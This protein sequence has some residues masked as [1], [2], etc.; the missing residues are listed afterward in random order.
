ML[1]FSC[2]FK[3]K[4]TKVEKVQELVCLGEA[5]VSRGVRILAWGAGALFWAPGSPTHGC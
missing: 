4:D 3:D 1:L 2:L 5:V